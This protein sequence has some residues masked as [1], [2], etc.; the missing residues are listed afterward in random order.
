[1]G[2]TRCVD[3]GAERPHN[4][5]PPNAKLPRWC[6]SCRETWAAEQPVVTKASW[7][8]KMAELRAPVES[9][10]PEV[11]V[12]R[13]N[14]ARHGPHQWAS[15]RRRLGW[16]R[17]VLARR[18]GYSARSLQE[19]EQGRRQPSKRAALTIDQI[20]WPPLGNT[21]RTFPVD[22]HHLDGGH[23]D[24]VRQTMGS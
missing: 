11:E 12:E 6:D 3:C 10:C 14:G 8:R 20:L 13:R 17:A 5:F 19:W 9:R 21:H 15:R 1:M 4:Q 18:C 16:S 24:A 2:L 22:P 7:D 23:L